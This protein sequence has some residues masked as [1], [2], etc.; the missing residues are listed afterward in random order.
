[1]AKGYKTGGRRKGTPN[2]LT[3]DLREMILG[4]LADARPS[5]ARPTFPVPTAQTFTRC[6]GGSA[7]RQQAPTCFVDNSD[8]VGNKVTIGCVLCSG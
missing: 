4:A 3:R 8:L 2:K 6:A 5:G 7:T 1:M